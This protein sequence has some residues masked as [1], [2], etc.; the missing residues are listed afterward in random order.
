MAGTRLWML[1]KASLP[2]LIVVFASCASSP[3]PTA[4]RTYIESEPTTFDPAFAVDY[5]SG[6]ICALMFDGLMR[7]GDGLKIEG[8]LA[9]SWEISR[10]GTLYSFFLKDA[11]F[12]D[13]T[14]VTAVDVKYSLE[15]L[16]APDVGSPRGWVVSAVIGAEA[17][18]SGDDQG[19]A[20][21]IALDDTTLSIELSKPF[22]PFLSMLAM[23]SAGVVPA[24]WARTAEAED[25]RSPV[26]SGPW[27]LSAWSEGQ[28]VILS[29][30]PNY[31]RLPVLERVVLRVLPERMTQVAEFEVGNLDHL[32]VPKAEIDRWSMDP[33]WG[34]RLERHVELAV[35]YIGINCQK[36]PFDD[37]RVRR[38]LNHAL[39][40]QAVVGSLMKD[41]A[42]PSAGAVPPGLPGADG[43]RPSYTYDVELA[44]ELLAQAG[45]ADGISMEIWYR[46]G[47]G[48][49]QVLEAV[50]AYLKA[51][52]VR[53]SIQ[54][55]E[56]GT[57]KEAVNRGVPDAY[58]LDWYADYP[59][60][61]NFLFPLFHSSN[62]GG[63]GNRA[64]FADSGVD[65]LLE[66]AGYESDPDVRYDLY[67]RIDELVHHD[68]PWIYLW[69]PVRVELRQPW[70]EG[71]VVHPLFYG[72]RYLTLS[73]TRGGRYAG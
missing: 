11:R 6:R 54:A 24:A 41:V 25:W 4:L 9:K 70:L 35:T 58:Y 36:A 57:L 40:R 39:D 29:R 69:H 46:D 3:D 28:S 12:S 31:R 48:A 20:G 49:E 51:A 32:S 18:R 5:P 50:Q 17:F 15:R 44:K 14:P 47:G 16:L 37:P 33:V 22:P 23:P 34:P 56:W 30:N 8:C 61:E 53:V 72:E 60:A 27:V 10:D 64:R 45:Y 19:L 52:G 1:C 26:C 63:G 67:R 43:G 62:W 71:P 13:G 68:A 21:I 66:L 42:V 55:R 59:D 38:A 7:P 2:I 65:S 73:K